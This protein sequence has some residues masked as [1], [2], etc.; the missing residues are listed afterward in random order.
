MTSRWSSLLSAAISGLCLLQAVLPVRADE[1]V[2]I[3][4]AGRAADVQAGARLYLE[5]RRA[6]GSPVVAERRQGLT[7]RGGETACVLCHRPSGMGGA[8]GS[9]AVPA[10]LGG[11]LRAPGEAPLQTLARKMYRTAPGVQR[12]APP[13]QVRPAYTPQ[14]LERALVQGIGAAGNTLDELMPRY[15]LDAD[16]VRDLLAYLDTLQIGRD[17]G[18][19]GRTLHLATIVTADTTEPVRQAGT[20]LLST[21][22]AER[23]PVPSSVAGAPPV[24]QLH[25]WTLGPDPSRWAAE[26]AEWQRRQPVFAVISGITGTQGRGAWQ[27]I[28]Q[29]CER[30]G[31]PCLLPHTASIDDGQPGTWTLHYNKGVSLEASGLAERFG[32]E[33]PAGGW[34]T[35]HQIVAAQDEASR[36]GARRLAQRLTQ[37]GISSLD[38]DAAAS[39]LSW[40]GQLQPRD[41]LVLWL[42][43][44]TLRRVTTAAPPPAEV[45]VYVSGELLE[46]DAEALPLP[47]RAEARITWPYDLTARHLPRI[48]RNAGKW[49]QASGVELAADPALIRLQGHSYSACEIAANA[50]RRMGP[51]V[52]RA[53]FMELVEGAEEAA[54]ATA[55]PRFTLGPGQ[56]A[57]SRGLGL[58]RFAPPALERLEAASDWFAPP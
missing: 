55:F 6:D 23:S 44:E 54:V 22:L 15:R 41:A 4:V 25:R 19:D 56:R 50:L 39:D 53:W 32:D 27:P 5:G 21:C 18:L 52:G 38:H 1:P 10:V 2:Q 3:R 46:L 45:P 36:T 24:W 28:Q 42:P 20:E 48:V 35:V 31:L 16:E 40:L 51:R 34:G 47:W 12:Q 33:P 13:S 14:T 7:I 17:P 8:E 58:V 9:T 57:G 29:Y 49:M 26:L 43:P 30:E 11:V 37:A